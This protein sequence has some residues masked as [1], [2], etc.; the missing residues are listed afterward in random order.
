MKKPSSLAQQILQAQRTFDTWPDEIKSS[1]RLYG[2]KNVFV[3]PSDG[4]VEQRERHA[5][6]SSEAIADTVN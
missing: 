6:V 4:K 5:I 1:V 3:S 2:P